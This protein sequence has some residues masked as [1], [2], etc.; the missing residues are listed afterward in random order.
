MASHL[1]FQV[2]RSLR[3]SLYNTE[4]K[5]WEAQPIGEGYV[6]HFKYEVSLTS[7]A[8]GQVEKLHV[9]GIASCTASFGFNTHS[10]SIE[11]VA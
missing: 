10:I 2:D 1:L 4:R 6:R 9:T 11:E 8:A 5:I 3:L 7:M